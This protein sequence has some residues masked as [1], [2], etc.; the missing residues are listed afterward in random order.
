MLKYTL[1]RVGLIFLT[2]FIILSLSFIMMQFTTSF[3][4]RVVVYK[5]S[6]PKMTLEEA[7]DY[8]R[9]MGWDDPVLEQYFDWMGGV[10]QGDWGVSVV[11]EVGQDPWVILT[12]FIPF[13]MS[14]NIWSLLISVPLSI[15]VLFGLFSFLH[16][17]IL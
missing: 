12:R 6:D 15:Y 10:I 2:L 13:T 7:Q 16:P 3:D 17:H 1:K 5:M 14:I 9:K 11:Y 4:K 8:G